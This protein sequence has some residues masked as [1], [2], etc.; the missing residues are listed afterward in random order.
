M[1]LAPERDLVLVV[2]EVSL[3]KI[4][5]GR[6]EPCARVRILSENGQCFDP[7]FWTSAGL[8]LGVG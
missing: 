3:T 1:S 2:N 6:A 8:V 5:K 4:P 7:S